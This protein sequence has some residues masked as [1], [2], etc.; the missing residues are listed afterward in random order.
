MKLSFPFTFLLSVFLIMGC[1]NKSP[2]E[3]SSGSTEEVKPADTE[4]VDILHNIAERQLDVK[5]GGE[6][7]TSYCYWEKLTKPVL[8]PLRTA[9]GR[10]VTRGFPVDPVPGERADHPHQLSS[11]F[12][13]GNVN[14]IDFWDNSFMYKPR[15][16][17]G[18]VVHRSVDAVSSG[19]KTAYI[20]VTMDWVD[21]EGKKVL[22]EKDRIYFRAGPGLRIVDRVIKL[23]A[24]GEKVVFN[25][26][27]E[28][29][30]GIRVTRVLEEATNQGGRFCG[31]NGQVV[32]LDTPDN[33]GVSGEYLSSEGLV[34]EKEVWGTRAKWCILR[35]T[36]EGKPATI[37]I[38]DHPDNPGY[39]TYWHA[40]GYGLFSANP[41]GWK[42]F[43]R[44]EKVFNFTLAPGEST[45]FRYRIMVSSSRL[46]R[47]E[48]EGLYQAWLAEIGG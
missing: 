25:D 12:T 37:G 4:T 34:G 43:T 19:K 31:A 42:D 26:T 20:D 15:K 46:E 2:R 47:E 36:V 14:G 38:F 3:S 21:S 48:T 11:W 8:Y 33:T 5:V 30:F 13:Y 44:G 27:K 41:F 23:A 18:R 6:S 1:G 39:P 22:E 28:G 9:D 40:R 17:L 32:E 24:L 45:V 10:V 16:N 7:F 29:A 35:G